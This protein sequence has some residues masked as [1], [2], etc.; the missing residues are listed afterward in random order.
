MRDR[1][2]KKTEAELR[3]LVEGIKD[4]SREA[5]ELVQYFNDRFASYGGWFQKRDLDL[6]IKLGSRLGAHNGYRSRLIYGAC[7]KGYF[8][9]LRP[10][11]NAR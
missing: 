10:I 8:S 7:T 3:Q 2:A 11:N 6:D 1:P 4:G 5:R 9:Q